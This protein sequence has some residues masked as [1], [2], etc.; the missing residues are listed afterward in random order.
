LLVEHPEAQDIARR[1]IWHV[2]APLRHD[3]LWR[4]DV[5]DGAKETLLNELL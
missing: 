5:S 3:P 2:D 1:Q 4:N